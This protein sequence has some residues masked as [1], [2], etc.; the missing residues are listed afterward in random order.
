M[1]NDA[2][3][4]N[5]STNPDPCIDVDN[6][7][8]CDDADDCILINGD[9]QDTDE[10]YLW[11]S[12]E[13][14]VITSGGAK[15]TIQLSMTN[16]FGWLTVSP[17]INIYEDWVSQYKR[18]YDVNGQPNEEN[19]DGFKR[20]MTWTSS[21][22][23]NTKVYGILPINFGKLNS[24]RHKA[25]PQITFN[26]IPDLRTS[27]SQIIDGYDILSGTSANSLSYGSRNVR[28]SLDNSFQLKIKNEIDEIEKID[29][30]SYNIT[31]NY[32]GANDQKDEFSLIDS[33]VSFK[34]PYGGELLYLH[35]QHDIYERDE[36]DNIDRP[37]LTLCSI[38]D[39]NCF[40][41]S[42]FLLILKLAKLSEAIF[43]FSPIFFIYRFSVILYFH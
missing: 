11:S 26:Y 22:S 17:R 20:R 37:N 19:R 13:D 12:Q 7:A 24:V 16:S 31:F 5:D 2:I 18:Y 39:E 14:A 38:P 32:G 6:D 8:L 3:C 28:F 35:M 9:C 27:S 33:R 15:N 1:D 23:L 29:F 40:K 21:L 34:K 42:F 36:F 25:T 43:A 4:D 10:Q 41:T 30:L